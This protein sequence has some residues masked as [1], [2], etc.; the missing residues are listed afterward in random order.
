MYHVVHMYMQLYC[1]LLSFLNNSM[2]I[3]L[4]KFSIYDYFQITC[5]LYIVSQ[6]FRRDLANKVQQIFM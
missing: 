3:Y 6:C 4:N 5:L 2:F 1:Y